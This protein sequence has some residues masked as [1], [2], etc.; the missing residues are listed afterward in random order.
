MKWKLN[1]ADRELENTREDV[2]LLKSELL[3]KNEII[4]SIIKQMV[5]HKDEEKSTSKKT[6][7]HDTPVNKGAEVVENINK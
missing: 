2:V 1:T 4:R 6:H 5:P 7:Q 3:S